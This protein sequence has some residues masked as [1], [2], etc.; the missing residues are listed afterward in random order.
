MHICVGIAGDEP[1]TVRFLSGFSSAKSLST[2]DLPSVEAFR[3]NISLNNDGTMPREPWARIPSNII[4]LQLR[5]KCDAN[6]LID[7]RYRQAV[8]GL[9]EYEDTVEVQVYDRASNIRKTIRSLYVVGYDGV[10]SAVGKS[11]GAELEGGPM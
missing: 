3:R 8:E 10:Q 6:P 9:V 2:Q 4:E 1:F 5:E 11:L 7:T